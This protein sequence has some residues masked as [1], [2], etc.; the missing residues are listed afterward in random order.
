[1]IENGARGSKA[2]GSV[3]T[4]CTNILQPVNIYARFAR[5]YLV[6]K[7]EGFTLFLFTC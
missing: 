1:M 4:E 7:M 3:H 2:E 5:H 6:Q